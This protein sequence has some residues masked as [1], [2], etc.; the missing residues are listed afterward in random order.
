MIRTAGT[1]TFIKE[2]A[3][4]LSTIDDR[5]YIVLIVDKIALIPFRPPNGI[6]ALEPAA[7][8]ALKTH[9]GWNKLFQ[10]HCH[11]MDFSWYTI[12]MKR[13]TIFE[14]NPYLRD[15]ES[16]ADQMVASVSSSTAIEIGRIKPSLKKAIV[17]KARKSTSSRAK[18]FS[19]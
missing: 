3:Q 4:M 19:R 8:L 7:S 9:R 6:R 16:Y 12:S 10:V 15:P 18:R 11:I 5:A 2:P 13:E 17:A 1:V 14:S